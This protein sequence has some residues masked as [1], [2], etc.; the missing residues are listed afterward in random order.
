MTERK[1]HSGILSYT[2]SLPFSLSLS[3]SLSFPVSSCVARSETRPGGD[4]KWHL[5]FVSGG[6][7]TFKH[8]SP[9]PTNVWH[10][11][12]IIGW[13]TQWSLFRGP[14][15]CVMTGLLSQMFMPGLQLCCLRGSVSEGL[16]WPC[17]ELNRGNGL[18]CCVVGSQLCSP[19]SQ[20]QQTAHIWPGPRMR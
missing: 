4:L 2:F 6:P 3:L 11:S 9:F 16:A 8:F 1:I 17:M 12:R 19:Q 7:L 20:R 15:G 14:P 5:V 18:G 13:F 10:W